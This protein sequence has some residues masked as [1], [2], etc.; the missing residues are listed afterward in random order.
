VFF[1][2]TPLE[3]VK[4]TQPT[5]LSN[6]PYCNKGP[7]QQMPISQVLLTAT[8]KQQQKLQQLDD[9]AGQIATTIELDLYI[10]IIFD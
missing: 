8:N 5:H 7:L 9:I 3:E 4:Q 6:T 2:S 1:G 10:I